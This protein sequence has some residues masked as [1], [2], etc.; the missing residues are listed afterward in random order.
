MKDEKRAIGEGGPLDGTVRPLACPFCGR[1]PELDHPDTLYP[2][3]IGWKPFGDMRSYVNFREV[4]REQWCYGMHC[5]ESCGGCG[6]EI[7]G[8]SAAEAL[9]KWNKRPNV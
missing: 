5:D 6:A 7:H 1:A 4:P 8:D 2:D 3:G 9:V